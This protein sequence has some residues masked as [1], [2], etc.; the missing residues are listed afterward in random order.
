MIKPEHLSDDVTLE[1]VD[2][3]VVFL[4]DTNSTMWSDRIIS[5]V[6]LKS[7]WECNV[8]MPTPTPTDTPTPTQTPFPQYDLLTSADT[9]NE[10]D[11]LTITLKTNH[12]PVGTIVNYAVT[13]PE[14]FTNLAPLNTFTVNHTVKYQLL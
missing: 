9:I 2:R 12:V 5:D 7:D 6:A 13:L 3:I 4:T 11:E 8:I 1:D 14:D 10:G